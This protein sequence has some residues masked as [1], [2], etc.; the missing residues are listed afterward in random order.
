MASPR[1]FSRY[2]FLIAWRYLRA[3]RAEGGVSVMTWISLIGIALGVMALIATLAVRTGFR[4]EFVDTILGANAHSTVYMSPTTLHNELTERNLYHPRPDHRITTHGRKA[5]PVPGV[6]RANPVVRAQVM[7]TAG[8]PPPMWPRSYGVTLDALKAMERIADP[9][10]RAAISPISGPW[11]R[12]RLRHRAR[13]GRGCR[14][15]GAADRAAGRQDPLWHH[16]AR[17]SYDVVYVFSAGRY[18]I[19]RTRIYMPLAEA[20]SYFNREGV[21]DEIEVFV[22]R[23]RTSTTGRRRFWMRRARARRSGPGAMPR[24]ISC[25]RW[26][27][28]M[29]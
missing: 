26:I 1:P 13:A 10:D 21:A 7:A 17:E 12:H 19:D 23:P 27:S 14:R 28:K 2:E 4:A 15:Q 8:R 3:R 29:T 25:G 9:S 18:D 24:A 20:Q 5:G 6:T 11:H 16:A 22:D